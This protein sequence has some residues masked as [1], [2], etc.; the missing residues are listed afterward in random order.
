MNEFKQLGYYEGYSLGWPGYELNIVD[1]PHAPYGCWFVLRSNYLIDSVQYINPGKNPLISSNAD[2]YLALQLNNRGNC[3]DRKGDG[4]YDKYWCHQALKLGYTGIV[5][6]S[7]YN[8]EVI[9]CNGGCGTVKFNGSC[10]P[11][12]LRQGFRASDLCDCGGT[13]NQS[14]CDSGKGA[15]FVY[16]KGGNVNVLKIPPLTKL[17]ISTDKCIWDDLNIL[18]NTTA[19]HDLNLTIVFTSNMIMNYFK[20]NYSIDHF[21]N[22][23]VEA[24]EREHSN[25]SVILN[26]EQ[27]A[28][29]QIYGYDRAD[30][31]SYLS[32]KNTSITDEVLLKQNRLQIVGLYSFY[33]KHYE[34][35]TQFDDFFYQTGYNLLKKKKAWKSNYTKLYTNIVGFKYASSFRVRDTM[36]E[37]R[38]VKEA[39]FDWHDLIGWIDKETKCLQK[40]GAKIVILLTDLGV[41]SAMKLLRAIPVGIDLILSI[42]DDGEDDDYELCNLH[43][44]YSSVEDRIVIIKPTI[45]HDQ[46]I[47][48]AFIAIQ[49]YNVSAPK[50]LKYTVTRMRNTFPVAKEI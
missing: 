9:I 15:D 42:H 31:M 3:L 11:I 20:S 19:C 12:E 30:Q 48:A 37:Y 29:L 7:Y 49:A 21:T 45:H 14:V 16:C 38:L 47:T 22:N 2:I 43:C 8:I 40:V 10:P 24:F 4:C 1:R 34:Y 41:R 18:S 36:I 28:N 17:G 46:D 44:D 33:W 26:F 6:H 5:R 32:H 35:S 25:V 13:S 50:S 39:I 23:W 27:H